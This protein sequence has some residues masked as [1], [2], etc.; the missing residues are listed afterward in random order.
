MFFKTIKFKKS[1][2]DYLTRSGL[3]SRQILSDVVGENFAFD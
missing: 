1:G 3:I 2:T